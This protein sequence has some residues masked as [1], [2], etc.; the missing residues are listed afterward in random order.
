M[1]NSTIFGCKLIRPKILVLIKP[2][3]ETR[4]LDKGSFFYKVK[5]DKIGVRIVVLSPTIRPSVCRSS[6]VLT[7]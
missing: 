4:G 2:N 1:T 7:L 6:P 5:G 3:K